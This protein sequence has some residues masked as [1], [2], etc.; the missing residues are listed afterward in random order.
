M[1]ATIY[2]GGFATDTIQAGNVMTITSSVSALVERFDGQNVIDKDAISGTKTLGPYIRTEQVRITAL[3]GNVSYSQVKAEDV[4]V[5]QLATDAAGNA[6]ML[7]VSN[8]L[9]PLLAPAKKSP[10]PFFGDAFVAGSDYTVLTGSPTVTVGP[11]PNGKQALK[12]VTGVGASCEISFPKLVGSVFY[13]DL[14]LSMHGSYT[15]G[16]LDYATMYVSP[17]AYTNFVSTQTPQLSSPLNSSTEQGGANNLYFNKAGWTT[18]GSVSYPFIPANAKLRITPKAGT[19]A[20]VYLYAAGTG[21]PNAKGRICVIWDD[22]YDSMF[23]LGI[24]VLQKLGIPQTLAVIGSAQDYGS[25]Y[26]YL[27]QLKAFFDSGNAL[28]AHGPW[29]NQGAGS[30]FSAYPGSTNPVADAVADMQKNRQ[31]LYDNRLLTTGADQCYVWPQGQTQQVANDTSLLDAA[32]AA[33]F[34]TARGTSQVRTSGFNAD[35]R[36]KYGRMYFP[37]VGKTWAGTTAAEATDVTATVNAINA[38]ATAGED[39]MLM[40][41]RIMADSTNDA[42]MGAAGSITTR[43]SDLVTIANAIAANISAGTQEA[44][45]MPQLAQTTYWSGF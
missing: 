34:T 2:Q 4:P 30:L 9:V 1:P 42:G 35:A 39:V 43:Y 5:A 13:G 25:G 33:G 44:V 18:T 11:G 10:I 24:P 40:L 22:G 7:S 19:S 28:V 16:S 20:T 3:S 23:Q 29:P 32:I 8:G 6:N 14:Y 31:Y 26:S 17:D 38:A 12:I 21:T 36:S 15:Q 45:T 27:R 41:H 37:I